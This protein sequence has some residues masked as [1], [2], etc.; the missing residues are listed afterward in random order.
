MR[1]RRIP[2]SLEASPWSARLSAARRAG[3]LLD[4]TVSDPTAVGLGGAGPVELAALADARAARYTPEPL[5]L[6]SAREA[7]AAA[8]GG[9]GADAP[10]PDD[11]VLTAS[12]SEAYAHLFAVLCDPGDVV[13][14]PRPGYPLIE[15]IAAVAGVRVVPWRLAWDGRWHLDVASLDAAL[16]AAAGRARALVTVEPNHPTGTCLAPDERTQLEERCAAAGL[17]LIADEVFQGAPRP[18]R[19]PLPSWRG[20]RTVPSAVLGGL[21]KFVGMPQ[22]K[23][24]W[25]T[26]A[27]PEAG[28]RALREGLE[29][30]ADLFLSVSTPV[31]IAAPTLLAARPRFA[32]A[33][34]ARLAANVGRLTCLVAQR[35]EAGVL[36]ADGGWVAIVRLPQR[37]DAEG[38]ALALLERGV[39]VHPGDLYDLELPSC[40]VV[41]LLPEPDVFGAACDRLAALLRV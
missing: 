37:R 30:V 21:S 12:T 13:L 41:S 25:I 26:L 4:L 36:A 28:R 24:G 1:S 7:V 6:R 29:W 11:V 14:V 10:S 3:P 18:G 9:D 32:A 22:M 16:A 27:G 5:G 39:A 40:V 2:E 23:L 33:L 34:E 38:W 19:G 31:Q 8:L 15:P 17:V 35:P 20:P